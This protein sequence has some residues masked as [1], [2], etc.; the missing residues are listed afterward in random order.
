M[1]FLENVLLGYSVCCYGVAR[2]F[3]NGY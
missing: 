2:V 1:M 3:W